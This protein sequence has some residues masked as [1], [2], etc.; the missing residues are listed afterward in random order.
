MPT[1]GKTKAKANQNFSISELLKYG[2]D[3]TQAQ[4]STL[5]LLAI[6]LMI[7]SWF[8]NWFADQL[9]QNL[10][11]MELVFRLAW[12]VVSLLMSMGLIR[13]VLQINRGKK[14]SLDSF[15]FPLKQV[16]NFLVGTI[17]VGIITLIGFL[18]LFIPGIY[19]SLR[20]EYV[21][22]LIVDKGMTASEAMNR[23]SEL[24]DG[25]KLKL[26]GFLLVLGLLNIAGALF[27]GLG[28]LLTVPVSYL[29]Q[30][31]LYDVLQKKK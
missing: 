15:K 23:S 16:F 19:F 4:A 11:F 27:F 2:W 12:I 9:A 31:R 8:G 28:L 24:T 25:I 6:G 5:V 1:K 30:A 7:V 20:Y 22:Y 26:F 3:K 18:V 14:V 13:S 10:P 29:A 21:S 17:L